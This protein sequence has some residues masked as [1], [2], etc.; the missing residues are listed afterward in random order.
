VAVDVAELSSG[1]ESAGLAEAPTRQP[2]APPRS[3]PEIAAARAAQRKA[4]NGASQ[5]DSP[6]ADDTSSSSSGWSIPL[7]DWDDVYGGIPGEGP[8]EKVLL[9]VLVIVLGLGVA[10]RITGQNYLLGLMPRIANPNSVGNP[11]AANTIAPRQAAVNP[12]KA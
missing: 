2:G 5:A 10:S 11:N 4:A 9:V 3:G 7:P 6:P 1:A 12:S 8:L